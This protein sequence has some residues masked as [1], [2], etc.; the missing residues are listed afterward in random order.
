MRAANPLLRFTQA[1]FLP[2]R[3]ARLLRSHR[4]ARRWA[5][6]IA[7]ITGL[8]LLAL[9]ALLLMYTGDL[10]GLLWQKPEG[11]WQ[12]L[13]WPAAVVL[14][15]VLLVIGVAT[16]PAITTAPL[17]DPLVAA[18]ERAIGSAG[19][20]AGGL[21]RV[22][23]ETV[24]SIVKAILRVGILL[25]GHAL[26]LL[27]W[28][29]PGPGHALW[30]G[31]SLLWSLFW[32]A[33]EYLDLPANRFGYRF[34]EVARVVWANSPEALGFASALYLILWVP[35][36]NAFFIP[37]G[38]VS[39]TLLFAELRSTARIGPSRSELSLG[40]HDGSTAHP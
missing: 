13:W 37:L 5:L 31:L 3:A 16:V 11:Y 33:F 23:R 10:L 34:R 20:S 26:L 22:A 29:I 27:L 17:A 18:T 8:L 2:L 40:M 1:F 14:F 12:L 25:L 32:L 30:T 19:P 6:A 39:A 9:L 35:V 15:A 24:D 28:L 21:I 38:I 4:E 7:A 36:L